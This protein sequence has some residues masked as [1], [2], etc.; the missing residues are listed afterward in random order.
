MNNDKPNNI[1]YV[2][3]MFCVSHRNNTNEIQKYELPELPELPELVDIP[4]YEESEERML[5]DE[6]LEVFGVDFPNIDHFQTARGIIKI[7]REI[8]SEIIHKGNHMRLVGD[9]FSKGNY[10]PRAFDMTL[11][12][13]QIDINDIVDCVVGIFVGNGFQLNASDLVPFVKHLEEALPEHVHPVWGFYV[14]DDKGAD[15]ARVITLA[16]KR[17]RK[18][19]CDI[20]LPF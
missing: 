14:M 11:Q 13:L 12:F 16:T 18:P 8:I 2:A 10:I 17:T 1:P 15:F 6:V 3:G 9:S 4:F 19:L 20:V 5:S 7:P